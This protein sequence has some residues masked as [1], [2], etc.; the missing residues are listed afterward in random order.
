MYRR[1]S[2][3]KQ[4]VQRI[5]LYTAMVLAVLGIV[6]GLI[7]LILGYRFDADNGR[8]EQGALLQ[9]AT[10]PAGATIQVDGKTINI[11]TPGKYT[12]LAG[13][14]VVVMQ[15]DGY[16]TWQKTVNA[17]AGTLTW[18]NY[19]R[20]V[21][22]NRPTQSLTQY[23]TMAASLA[24]PDGKYIALQQDAAQPR[25]DIVDIR[26]DN[27]QSGQIVLPATIV[28]DIATP[29]VVHGFTLE[30][31]D[32]GS[33]YLLVSHTYGDKKEWLT[34]D[35]RDVAASRNVTTLLDL[36]IQSAVFAGTNGS[37]LYALSGG[38]IRKLDLSAG[39]ISRSLISRVASFDLFET[40]VITYVGID[41]N[42]ATKRVLGLYREG[43]SAPH[44]LRT[45]SSAADVPIRIATT[46]YFNQDYVAL[47]EGS[48]VTVLYGK[49]PESGSDD[50]SGL[51]EFYNFD[52]TSNVDRLG[53]SPAG[54]Y[55]LVQNNSAFMSLDIEHQNVAS[56]SISADP[57]AVVAPLQWLDN[58]YVWSSFGDQLTMREFD[59]ANVNT[60]NPVVAGQTVTITE[61]GRWMYSIGKTETGYSLQRVRMILQ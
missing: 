37:I 35:T 25:L 53:F 5:A 28:T 7:F 22:K 12:V 18:L 59:G 38:D 2:K 26:N 44:V 55:L 52:F 11:R 30:R 51:A 21:P 41:A 60:I 9:F 8:V 15:K 24:S 31:W 45:V 3:K 32:T 16:E 4:L 17:R 56:S 19:A 43:D 40:N 13:S 36:D 54:D 58:D 23:A 61:N 27:I 1:P 20:L 10:Q 57:G 29:G 33:R 47:S 42:D 6:T 39:T 14:H 34:V 48:K 50:T 49:Y 46:R